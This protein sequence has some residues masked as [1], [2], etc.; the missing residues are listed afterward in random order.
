MHAD[1]I[2]LINDFKAIVSGTTVK[3]EVLIGDVISLREL[4]LENALVVL[5][6]I[7]TKLEKDLNTAR[8]AITTAG[9][10]E[11]DA[12]KTGSC[13]CASARKSGCKF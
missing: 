6:E 8:S 11:S 7:Q 1:F 13:R 4:K 9:Q 5:G 2:P 10:P 12:G 3:P